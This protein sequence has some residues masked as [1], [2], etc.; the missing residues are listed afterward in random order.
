MNCN[1]SEGSLKI[2]FRCSVEKRSSDLFSKSIAWFLQQAPINRMIRDPSLPRLTAQVNHVHPILSAVE[3]I[4]MWCLSDRR[5][6]LN[7]LV[8]L[9]EN[10]RLMET[11]GRTPCYADG[12]ALSLVV[13]DAP[14]AL[15][16]LLAGGYL[17]ALDDL[18]VVCCWVPS[19]VNKRVGD[20]VMGNQN[21]P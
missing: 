4:K 20:D 13:L 17:L 11:V 10:R 21:S 9:I 18:K 2:S 8:T 1:R 14:S 12:L 19:T 5:N 15:D 7:Q 6:V 3:V 16:L